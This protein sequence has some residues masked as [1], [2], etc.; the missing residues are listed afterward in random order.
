M[1]CM[2][3]EICFVMCF[4]IFKHH[5]SIILIIALSVVVSALPECTIDACDGI[6]LRVAIKRD[7]EPWRLRGGIRRKGIFFI[8][9]SALWFMCYKLCVD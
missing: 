3:R 2:G 6:N 5:L 1:T 4:D 9:I 7:L 8:N